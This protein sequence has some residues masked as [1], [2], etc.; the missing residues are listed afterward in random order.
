M[1]FAERPKTAPGL[2]GVKERPVLSRAL[3]MTSIVFIT[4]LGCLLSVQA[5]LPRGEVHEAR[6]DGLKESMMYL[7][8]TKA[9]GD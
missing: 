7:G 3:A 2:T 1:S 9:G 6:W 8:G 4:F 5:F